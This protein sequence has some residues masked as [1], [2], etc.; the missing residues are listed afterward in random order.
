M[1]RCKEFGSISKF[2]YALLHF[3][4]D[5][6]SR[7]C[8]KLTVRIGLLVLWSVSRSLVGLF[9][10]PSVRQWVSRPVGRSTGW[11]VILQWKVWKRVFRCRLVRPSIRRLVRPLRKCKNRVSWLFLATVRSYT[12]SNDQPTC[13][14]SLLYYSF[15]LSIRPSVSPY[16]SHA[17]Y[18]Q[19]QTGRI[20]TMFSL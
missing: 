10:H 16:I 8:K 14:E 13:F 1:Y 4:S 17:Q 11:Y 18:T 6:V 9:V 12:E 20:I 2:I 5:V 7:L 15:H 3:S 19:T